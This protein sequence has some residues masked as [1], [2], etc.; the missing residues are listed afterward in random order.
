MARRDEVPNGMR[1]RSAIFTASSM[2]YRAG[3]NILGDGFSSVESEW[4]SKRFF[5]HHVEFV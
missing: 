3:K 2:F 5:F 1:E 4:R